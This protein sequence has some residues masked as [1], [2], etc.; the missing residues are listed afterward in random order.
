MFTQKEVTLCVIGF[1][2]REICIGLYL[3]SDNSCIQFL[4]KPLQK[5]M[6]QTL[7]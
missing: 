7:K 2:S 3:K 1:I 4:K 5:A 6:E